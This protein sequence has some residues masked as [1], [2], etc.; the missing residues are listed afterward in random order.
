MSIG[1]PKMPAGD[2]T[3][4]SLSTEEREKLNHENWY[5]SQKAA[6]EEFGKF[7]LRIN[8][9]IDWFN[10][11]YRE[12][13]E[14]PVALRDR[15]GNPIAEKKFSEITDQEKQDHSYGLL[16]LFDNY[17]GLEFIEN[18]FNEPELLKMADKKLS[19]LP[20]LVKLY[21]ANQEKLKE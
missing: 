9:A 11:K 4:Q 16:Y 10:D 17:K 18:F 12:Y 19:E 15:R 20:K 7:D 3:A 5:F 1:E 13:D 14:V 2:K 6:R 8:E 21:R